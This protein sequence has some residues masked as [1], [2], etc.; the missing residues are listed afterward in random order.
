MLPFSSTTD[1]C[2]Q[3]VLQNYISTSVR[4]LVNVWTGK[5]QVKAGEGRWRRMRRSDVRDFLQA[6]KLA[7]THVA[8]FFVTFLSFLRFAHTFVTLLKN[9]TQNF[10]FRPLETALGL[11]FWDWRIKRN[12]DHV[13]VELQSSFWI[14]D[15]QF[16][17]LKANMVFH[18][19]QFMKNLLSIGVWRVKM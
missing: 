13:Q 5:R 4:Y 12:F 19:A 7:K 2:L 18:L 8:H 17:T 9:K 15:K 16:W 14:P 1:L 3:I 10:E 11:F 6:V